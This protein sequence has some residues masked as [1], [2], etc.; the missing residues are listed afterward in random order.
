MGFSRDQSEEVAR[1]WTAAMPVVLA[2]LRSGVPRLHDAQDLLQDVAVEAVR[3]F[4]TYDPSRSFVGWA[5]GI[6]RNKLKAHYRDH[7]TSQ[8]I[9]SDL[10]LSRLAEAM[11]RIARETTDTA[12]ALDRCLGRVE[13]KSMQLLDMR[14]V[15]D[16]SCAEIAQATGASVS[17]V[18]VALHRLRAVLHRCIEERLGVSQRTS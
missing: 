5:L 9:L 6:A 15:Q 7:L 18:K 2:F 17:A 10:A 16:L 13:A 12:D 14:Y 8:R 4:D 3:R 11:Q 1:L